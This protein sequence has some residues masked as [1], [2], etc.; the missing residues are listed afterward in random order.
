MT[1]PDYAFEEFRDDLLGYLASRFELPEAIV[2]QKLG[3]FLVDLT[4]HE[5]PR[6]GANPCLPLQRGA[7]SGAADV[8]AR[9]AGGLGGLRSAGTEAGAKGPQ[10]EF[11]QHGMSFIP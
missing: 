5:P 3:D 9:F 8:P 11:N 1:S 2:L 10:Q 7:R 6:S 4:H